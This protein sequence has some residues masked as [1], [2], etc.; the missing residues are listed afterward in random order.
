MPTASSH[1]P[2]LLAYRE[3]FSVPLRLTTLGALPR[4]VLG[5]LECW[6]SRCLSCDVH[7]HE[8]RGALL[9]IVC[10]LPGSREAHETAPKLGPCP[11]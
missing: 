6:R 5:V 3:A 11:S 7:A 8:Q 9:V 2:Y 10:V 4:A 1:A